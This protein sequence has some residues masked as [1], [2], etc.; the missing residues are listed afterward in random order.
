M[1]AA[2]LAAFGRIWSATRRHCR[3]AASA[4]ARDLNGMAIFLAIPEADYIVAQTFGVDGGN[5][6][7]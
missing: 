6:L 1:S 2:S 3:L 5:W 7:A 4:T